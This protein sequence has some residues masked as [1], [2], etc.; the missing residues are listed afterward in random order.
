MA[1]FSALRR[2][3]AVELAD[4]G[5]GAFVGVALGKPVAEETLA[6]STF[7]D[8]AGAAHEHEVQGHEEFAVALKTPSRLFT[9][10]ADTSTSAWMA[11]MQSKPSQTGLAAL[12]AA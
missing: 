8:P 10:M 6:R 4:I 3:E 12:K 1:A 2:F 9:L 5:P 11:L 7:A